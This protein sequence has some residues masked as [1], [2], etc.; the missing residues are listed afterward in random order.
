MRA[1]ILAAGLGTRMRP[2]TDALPKP[3]LPVGDST[4]IEWHLKKL[5]QAGIRDVVINVSY[6]GEK[7]QQHLGNGET[8]GLRI[9]YS[10]EKQPLETAGGI[11]NA[12]SLLASGNEDE[13][14]LLINGDV[15]TD[16]PFT[17]LVARNLKH[18]EFAHLVLV[19]NPEHHP[20]GD[21]SMDDEGR[22][23]NKT[24]ESYTFSGIS[25]LSTSLFR[26][27][28]RSNRLGDVFRDLIHKQELA[29]NTQASAELYEGKWIDVGTPER[30]DFLRGILA[31]EL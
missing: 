15:W 16:F 25:L 1:M 21:F 12:L 20:E 29:K 27:V 6:L 24:E 4:L 30:L 26:K 2:L 23:V 19:K 8:Y 3:L 7:I 28:L 22:L 31:E 13:N 5:F 17:T 14:F 11:Q 10:V 9:H 18:N